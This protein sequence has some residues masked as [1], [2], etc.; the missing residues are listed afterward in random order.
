MLCVAAR[1]LWRGDNAYLGSLDIAQR[2]AWL[3]GSLAALLC[4][5][6]MLIFT[7][8]SMCARAATSG[9]NSSD[10]G[11]LSK[12]GGILYT[13]EVSNGGLV[14]FGRVYRCP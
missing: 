8:L 7:L 3:S 13:I 2:K 12:P 4:L 9:L 10:L 11:A 14:T 5:G 1:R 6:V